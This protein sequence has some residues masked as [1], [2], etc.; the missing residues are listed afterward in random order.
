MELNYYVV[1]RESGEIHHH[2]TKGQKWGRRLYQNKDGSLTPL[3]RL[4]YRKKQR[5]TAVKRAASLEKARKA[6]VEAKAEAEKQKAREEHKKKIV[7]SGT[8]DEVYKLRGELSKEEIDRAINRINSETRLYELTT[9]HKAAV[10]AGKQ[11]AQQTVNNNAEKKL[12]VLD[13]VEKAAKTADRVRNVAETGVNVWNTVAKI[14]NSF[15][16]KRMP[17]INGN[18][19]KKEEKKK[20]EKKK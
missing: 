17:V 14:N 5:E 3:G 16:D 19:A 12:S 20:E 4:R 10:E 7:E 1:D 15:N 6:K 11:Q 13:R 2:G 18:K 9:A 8:A